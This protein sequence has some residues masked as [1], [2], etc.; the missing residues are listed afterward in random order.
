MAHRLCP[1]NYGP[2]YIILH[3]L[4]VSVGSLGA[5]RFG[6][7]T[8]D[9]GSAERRCPRCPGP[10]RLSFPPFWSLHGQYKVNFETIFER[11]FLSNISDCETGG[12]TSRKRIIVLKFLKFLKFW[13]SECHG[14]ISITCL[15]QP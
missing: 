8:L 6:E 2:L 3:F 9:K 10:L 4:R 1:M 15:S 14:I 7:R 12:V 13:I 5:K 11:S